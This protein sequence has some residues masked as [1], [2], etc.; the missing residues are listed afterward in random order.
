M[1]YLEKMRGI[2][3]CPPRVSLEEMIWSWVGAFLGI[4]LVGLIQA[5]F[6]D[7]H[8]MMLQ[9]GSFGATAVLV[10]GAVRSPLA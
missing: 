6:L 2:S 4:G 3:S 10:F 8:G 7:Q 1:R 9:V 5:M